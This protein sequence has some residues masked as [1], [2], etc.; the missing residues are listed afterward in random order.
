MPKTGD[1]S[2]RS[3][4]E[5]EYY[6]EYNFTS[7]KTPRS[8]RTS[9]AQTPGSKNKTN[10]S[11]RKLDSKTVGYIFG[12]LIIFGI[13]LG[14]RNNQKSQSNVQLDHVEIPRPL[15]PRPGHEPNVI[16]QSHGCPGGEISSNFIYFFKKGEMR[17]AQHVTV[18][19][20]SK[21]GQLSIVQCI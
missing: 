3:N 16:I 2:A 1:A 20:T 4:R 13:I 12:L 19:E 21:Y 18:T 6:A 7:R 17:T 14:A 9:R 5:H 15:N 11:K 10:V 8:T